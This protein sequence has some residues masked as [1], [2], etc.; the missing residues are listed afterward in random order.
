MKKFLTEIHISNYCTDHNGYMRKK[1]LMVERYTRYTARY[2]AIGFG[3]NWII[4]INI[5][6]IYNISHKEQILNRTL[7]L[8][9]C[10]YMWMPFDYGYNFKNWII[11]HIINVYVVGNG[12]LIMATSHCLNYMLI[13]HSIGHIQILKHTLRSSFVNDVSNEE[14]RKRLIEIIKHHAFIIRLF[15]ELQAAFGVNVAANYFHNLF[16]DSFILYQVLNGGDIM[17]Y[18]IMVFA[19]IGELVLMSFVIEEI[20]KQSEDLPEVVYAI[21]WEN[22]TVSNQKIVLLSLSRMQTQMQFRALG[23]LKA[24][25]QPMVSILKTTFSYYVMLKTSIESKKIK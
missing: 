15:K 2:L 5:P 22:M 16:S 12:V 24:G 10:V 20:R 7:Q 4:W 17:S 8:Q 14:I 23:G 3:F 9:T 11:I 18:A 19:Y 6:L 13:Y 1:L 25:V 21:P